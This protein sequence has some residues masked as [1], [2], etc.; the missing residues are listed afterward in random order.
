MKPYLLVSDLHCHTWQAFST[1]ENGINSRL[2]IILDELD[3][4]V[5]VLI[6]AGG[7]TLV[8]AG[9]LFHTRGS[10]DPEVFNL[11]HDRLE[12]IS[13]RDIIVIAIPG[14]HD[15]KSKET[16]TL[17]NSFQSFESIGLWNVI[18]EP[19]YRIDLRTWLI[20]W[21]AT[22]DKLLEAVK[23]ITDN[24]QEIATDDLIIHRGIDGVLHGVPDHGLTAAEVASWGFKRVFAGDYHNHK[25][26]EDGKVI[27]IGATTHQRWN[28]VGTKA[29]FILVYPDK[30]DWHASHAPSFV[31]ITGD[32]P[33]EEVGLIA[34]GNYVRIRSMK[35][36]D[37][38]TNAFREALIKEGARGVLFQTSREVVTLRGKKV[39]GKLTTIDETVETYI[40]DLGLTDYEADA[41][42]LCNTILKDV[43]SIDTRAS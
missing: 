37:E 16:T 4:A 29:G 25:V 35:L 33:E 10:I 9:D 28:D 21:C 6:K 12:K 3:R 30:I 27:S 13:C 32:T 23:E 20:P 15:L 39:D 41:K 26:M 43:R 22:K 38:E 11:V 7:N 2:K 34:D 24:Y 36:T 42:A 40:S 17:G 18:T 5:D 31:E 1:L 8:I 19:T 14:N